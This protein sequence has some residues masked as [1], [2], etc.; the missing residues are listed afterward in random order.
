M[1]VNNTLAAFWLW[2]LVILFFFWPSNASLY[3]TISFSLLHFFLP[4]LP[5]CWLPCSLL[6][7]LE[8][9]VTVDGQWDALAQ[10]DFSQVR[11]AA[12]VG[13]FD[14]GCKQLLFALIFFFALL[15]K[16]KKGEKKKNLLK[17]GQTF[18]VEL[19]LIHYDID[20]R[21]QNLMYFTCHLHQSIYRSRICGKIFQPLQFNIKDNHMYVS[22]CFCGTVSMCVPDAL[23]IF[24]CAAYAPRTCCAYLLCCHITKIA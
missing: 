7:F 14:W 10:L 24:E 12:P 20:V 21:C 15:P 1:L 19:G 18:I 22:V 16:K 3:F 8:V 6:F 2:S 11:S 4:P 9:V 13:L 5:R 23:Y 17:N